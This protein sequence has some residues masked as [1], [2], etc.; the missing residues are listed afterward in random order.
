PGVANP[1]SWRASRTSSRASGPP[2]GRRIAPCSTFSK[3]RSTREMRKPRERRPTR[4]ERLAALGLETEAALRDQIRRLLARPMEERTHFLRVRREATV[5]CKAA[6]W[7][8]CGAAL[9][10]AARLDPDGERVPIVQRMHESVN[11]ALHP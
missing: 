11:R 7:E 6:E 10:E 8:K 5:T 9:D 3:R 1:C 2:I 4:A